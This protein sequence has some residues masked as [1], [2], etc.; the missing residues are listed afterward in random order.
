MGTTMAEW[1]DTGEKR[2]ERG[3]RLVATNE[4]ATLIEG[5]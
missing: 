5:N 1:V 2:D 3:R 4:R